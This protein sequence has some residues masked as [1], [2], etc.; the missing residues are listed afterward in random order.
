VF[1][2]GS[3]NAGE[4]NQ[5]TG[6]TYLMFTPRSNTGGPRF[7]ATTTSGAGEIGTTWTNAFPIGQPAHVAI[8]YN[9]VAGT[10]ALYFNGQRVST[11][12]ATVPLSGINDVNVWLGRS[13][14]PDPP[15]NA[16]LDE[17]RIYSGVL[18]D[19]TVAASFAAGPDALLGQ[20]P[21]LFVLRAG[22][23]IQLSW[24]SDAAGYVLEVAANLNTNASWTIVTNAP[25]S[26]NG[27]QTLTLP[28]TTSN[29][30]FRLHK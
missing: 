19:S 8:S 3:N 27:Q 29:Q 24:P 1:D 14:W 30:F 5:G 2:F 9:F 28:I 10:C 17:F 21:N 20:R 22:N 13:N 15:L 26:Q 16:Q 4:D 6:L 18:S 12:P 25:T 11:G 23:S 7:A